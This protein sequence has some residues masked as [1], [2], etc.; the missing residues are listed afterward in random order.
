[1]FVEAPYH[2]LNDADDKEDKTAGVSALHAEDDPGEDLPPVVGAC[3]PLETPG[4]RDALV[5][6]AGW[7][8]VS[9]VQMAHEVD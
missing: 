7:S 5:L 4:V 9:Q 1:M 2:H 8:Q 3:E 6:G